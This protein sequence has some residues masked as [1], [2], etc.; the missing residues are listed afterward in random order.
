[1]YIRIKNTLQT[2]PI[3]CVLVFIKYYKILQHSVLYIYIYNKLNN[4]FKYISRAYCL[5]I[6][7]Y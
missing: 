1:M 4:V 2:N 7:Y 6:Y 5:A 3:D